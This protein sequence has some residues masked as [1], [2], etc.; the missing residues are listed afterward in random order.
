VAPAANPY[1][2]QFNSSRL[3][4]QWHWVRE[5]PGYWS[6]TAHPGYLRIITEAK[7]ILVALGEDTAPIL[8]QRAPAGD[9]EISTYV[10]MAPTQDFQQ[11]GLLLYGDDHNYVRETFIYTDSSPVA[12]PQIEMTEMVADVFSDHWSPLPPGPQAPGY[13]LQIDKRG[14][15]YTGYASKDGV[16][17]RR[18]ATLSYPQLRPAQIGLS[19]FSY[20]DV[21]HIPADFYFFQEGGLSKGTSGPL[22]ARRV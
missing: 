3:G 14:G 10:R 22:P 12:G 6:L 19:A 20:D 21:P 11:G 9:F 16:H 5:S 17:W 13:Y 2:D 18:V 15:T 7:E 1:D 8:L 4:P